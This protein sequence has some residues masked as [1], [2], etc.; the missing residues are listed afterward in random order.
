MNTIPLPTAFNARIRTRHLLLLDALGRSGVLRRAAAEL[1]MTQPTAT[2]LLQ[3]LEESLGVL[4]FNRKSRGMEPTTFGEVMIRHAR[5]IIGDL[6]YAREELAGLSEGS[7]GKV[8]LGAVAGAVPNLVAPAIARLKSNAPRLK[9]SVQ[10]ESSDILLRAL[11]LGELDLMVGRVVAG[12]NIDDFRLE[13]LREE[14]MCVVANSAHP[15]ARRENLEM[16]DLMAETWIL[17]PAEGAVRRAVEFVWQDQGLTSLPDIIETSS[18]VFT[19]A[20]LQDTNMISV[21][22]IN[23]AL[24]H[25]PVGITVLPLNTKIRMERLAVVTRRNSLLSPAVE[26]LLRVLR[27][28]HAKRSPL[29]AAD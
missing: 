29:P 23:V 10:V 14:P 28:I 2:Q 24:Y 27:N 20:M 11:V 13:I 16:A 25:A 26:S 18:I 7:L 21:I 19:T 15:L 4:L 8:S 1:N 6:A 3:Q 12:F 5:S 9:V 17:Q 22:P